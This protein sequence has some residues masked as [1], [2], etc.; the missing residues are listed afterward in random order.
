MK[1]RTVIIFGN[2]IDAKTVRQAV[3]SKAKFI[4]KYGD[5][6]AADYRFAAEDI[7]ALDFIGAKKLVFSE[8]EQPLTD[9]PLVVGNIRMGFGHYRISIAMAS[10]ARALGYT[11]YWLDLAGFDA[12]GSKMIRSQNDL[13]SLGSRISQTSRLFT[14]S[15]G[16]P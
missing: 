15:S 11:P 5:D 4:R 13:Y 3:K 10:C 8:T 1:D 9:N 2:P 7:P 6:S 16:N 12:T 14:S